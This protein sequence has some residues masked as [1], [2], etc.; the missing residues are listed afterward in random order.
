MRHLDI[1][2][3]H[4]ARIFCEFSES[5]KNPRLRVKYKKDLPCL[6]QID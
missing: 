6:K 5:I 1:F 2:S 3:R 4:L